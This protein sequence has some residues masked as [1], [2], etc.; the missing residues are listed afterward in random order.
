[1]RVGRV[2]D[3][4]ELLLCSDDTVYRLVAEGQI[5]TLRRVGGQL[6]FDLDAVEKWLRGD[7]A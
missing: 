1:M 5:P 7:A 3:V 4:M 2:Q 6:R